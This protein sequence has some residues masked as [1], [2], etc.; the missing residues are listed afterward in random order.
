MVEVPSDYGPLGA[1][2]V[3]EPPVTATAAAIGNAIAD[4]AGVRLTALPMTPPMILA[5]LANGVREGN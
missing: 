3:G 4:A 1:K 2:G 5:A